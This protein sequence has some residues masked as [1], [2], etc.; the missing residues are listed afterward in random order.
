MRVLVING[1]CLERN[2]SANLCHLAYIRGML[3]I[4]CEV[5]ILCA[6]GRDYELDPEMSIPSEARVYTYYGVSMYE[7]LSLSKKAITQKNSHREKIKEDSAQINLKNR[8][9]K[10]AKKTVRQTLKK[11]KRFVL[12][13]YGVHGIY[14]PF[15]KQ[16]MK[17]KSSD[18]YDFVVS[19]STPVTSHLIAGKLIKKKH[20]RTKHWIQIWEDPWYSD[21][22]GF[23]NKKSI[24]REE[25]HL[26]DM[27]EMIVYVSPLTLINQQR[28]FLDNAEKMRW[29]PLP[30]YYA[31]ADSKK[32]KKTDHNTYGY[33][34]NYYSA[35]R[36]LKPFYDAAKEMGIE[37]NIC[38][39]P[40]TLFEGTDRIHIYP[41]LSLDKLRPIEDE[42]DVLVFLCN[43]GGGQIP[44]K[45]Y[46]YSATAKPILFILDGTEEEQKNL[47][48]YFSQ[49]HRY[50]FCSNNK[51][52]IIDTV[53]KIDSGSSEGIIS[54][55][56]NDF[57][58]EQ[59]VKNIL[60]G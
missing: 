28:I 46:Q 17:Y 57:T 32:K 56:I 29:Q 51:D 47:K 30:S 59:I 1:D 10:N 43:R 14:A 26:L 15:V 5:D 54:E 60:E 42:T 20:I 37:T 44:G 36:D 23:N 50:Y 58:P 18:M 21:I 39:S 3:N 48:E 45:I 35:A 24:Y 7:K 27:A 41:R 33:F 40:H 52:D 49:F 16:A 34:G 31:D 4:G 53:K 8:I 19:L 22:Y 6:D 55:P 9:K 12:W 2:S 38:G 25:K 13:T 11:T